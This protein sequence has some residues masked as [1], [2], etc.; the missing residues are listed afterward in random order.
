MTEQE[1]YLLKR[2]QKKRRLFAFLR[3]HRHELFDEAGQQALEALYRD[4]G[5]G[6]E[7][8][9]PAMLAIALIMQ[10][11]LGVSDAEAVELS[12]VDL[13]WQMVLGRLG[14]TTPAFSQG[15]LFEFRERLIAHDMD[16]RLLERTAQLARSS[17]GFD[18][19]K[20]PKTLR[21]ALDW[22]PLAG[23]G[24]VEDTINLIAHAA[25]KVV[26]CAAELLGREV[27]TVCRQAGIPVLLASS[28]KKA[29]DGDGSDQRPPAAAVDR[30]AR[31]VVSL[32]RWLE[33]HLAEAVEPPLA[34]RLGVLRQIIDQDLEA[35]PAGGGRRLVSGVAENRRIAVEDGQMR[36]G[37]KSKRQR[38]DGYQRH[39]ATDWDSQAIL[40]CAVTP[41]NQAEH[42]AFPKLKADS[43]AQ[44]LRFGQAHFDRGYLSSPTV[45]QIMAEGGEII[46][47]PWRVSNGEFF[48]K[49][50][51]H[52]DLRA[53]TITCPAGQRKAI[54]FGRTVTFPA[55]ACDACAL[56]A[57]CTSARPGQGRSVH[58]AD[59][60]RLH[61]KRRTLASTPSGRQRFRER[62]PVE[63]RLAPIGQRQ[64]LR[65]RYLGTRKNLYDLRRAAA[66]QN[67]Q[68]AQR[69]ETA[70]CN[71]A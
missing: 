69:K 43:D 16:R 8:L 3:E 25:R 12:V 36:H 35:D 46:C 39:V 17:Q 27:E 20:L 11:Y 28:A 2:C 6:K 48:S 4:T 21:I 64:G 34:C 9:C 53:K 40:A 47:K 50:D 45:A 63:H 30:L 32:E 51:F 54:E 60:E 13:R 65:A 66:I 44:G 67:L 57:Q 71:A 19:R 24:R 23:A 15:A 33:R 1:E 18:A 41:A 38:S 58:I 61:K 55:G 52:L 29:L 7:P 5:A 68:T 26:G 42:E 59:A 14:E 49:Q 56:R 31:E 37:R 10:G 70:L 62:V 22:S